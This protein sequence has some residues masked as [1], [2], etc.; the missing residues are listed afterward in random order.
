MK[1]QFANLKAQ[2]EDYKPE[3]DTAI[4]G[5][6]DSAH[7]IMG[8]Q[9]AELEKQLSE[10]TGSYAITCAN[11]TDALQI[12]MLAMDIKP[13]DEVITTPFTF[14]A[15]AEMIAAVGAIP[16]FVD[17]CESDF[18][19]DVSKIE[20]AITAKTKA[21]IPVSLYGQPSDM[22]AVNAIAE[23]HKLVVIED[24]AQ[25]FGST[26]KGKRS[27]NLSK[28]ATTSFFPAK[29]MGCYGDG[30][31]VFTQ[32]AELAAKIKSIRNHGQEKRYYHQYIGVNS[33]LDTIQAAILLV[34]IKY[35]EKEI[36]KRQELAERYTELLKGSVRTPQVLA[37]RTSVWAQYTVRSDNRDALQEKL[38]QAG[39]PTAVHYPRP[40]HLQE[41]F[42]F[43]GYK[44]GDFPVAEK[45][46]SEVISL[47]MSAH[48]TD[49]EQV[50]ICDMIN[51]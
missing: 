43:C 50:Y 18:N 25:S 39:V 36:A 37:D 30:G 20:A 12:A 21:I 4:E 2:Y 24:G 38:K 13:G 42:E 46:A 10:F 22:D 45:I 41:A 33:R 28:L 29:P 1:V 48:L 44:L 7:F 26:Y 9:V 40:L 16:V 5:V 31:A 27:A 11:G 34:K 19:I 14:I 47:P 23:K 32:D 49:E 15:T 8:P 6:L 35:Y 17:V 3:I 51:A